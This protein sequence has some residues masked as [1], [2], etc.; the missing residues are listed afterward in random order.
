MLNPKQKVTM[1]SANRITQTG[2]HCGFGQP[3]NY[4]E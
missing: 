4:Q 2:Y 3:V 1:L